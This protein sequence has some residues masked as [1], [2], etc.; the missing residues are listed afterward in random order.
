MFSPSTTIKKTR[1]GKV[2]VSTVQDNLNLR[3]E[4]LT[5]LGDKWDSKTRDQVVDF[6][7]ED[8]LATHEKHVKKE[9]RLAKARISRR[10]RDQA[11]AD[12]GLVKVRSA[13]GKIYYE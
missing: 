6:T 1:I 11:M 13:S 5:F 8:A 4:T 12:I 2:E 9:K 3:F 7:L 10:E